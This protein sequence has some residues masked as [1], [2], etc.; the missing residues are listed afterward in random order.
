MISSFDYYKQ[1][2]SPNMYLC[3]PDR[4]FICALNAENRHLLLRFNDLSELS[5]TVPKISGTEDHY[6]L[7]ESKRLLFVEK[8]GWFQ[9]ESV[10]EKIVGEQ[11]TKEVK[12]H[13]HQYSFKNRGFISEERVYMFYNPYDPLDEKYDSNNKAAMPS[14]I[15]QLHQQLGV[16]V[17]LSVSDIEPSEDRGDWT[18]I[19]IDPVL[20]FRAR[21]YGSMYEP[22][23]NVENVCRSFEADED[24]N[25]YDFIINKVESAFEVIFEFDFLYH[26]IKVKTLDAITLPTDIYLSFDNIVNSLSVKENAEDIVT[27]MSCSGGD[28]DIRTVNPMGTNY[29][30]D[31]SYYKKEK[32]DDGKVEYPWMS[33]ELIEALNEWETEFE[34]YQ[35]EYSSIVVN[36]QSKYV[37]KTSSDEKIQFANLK[38]KDLQVARDQYINGEDEDIDGGG[39]TTAETVNVNG[40]SLKS[41]TRFYATPFNDSAIVVG[42]IAKPIITKGDSGIYTFVFSDV[43]VSGTVNSLIQNYYDEDSGFDGVDV[44]LYFMDED[45]YSYCK[46]N[47]GYVLDVAKDEDGNT[48]DFAYRDGS[49]WS[50]KYGHITIDGVTFIITKERVVDSYIISSGSFSL[51]FT[52]NS[53]FVY[54]GLRYRVTASADGIVSLYRYYVSGFDRFT[55]CKETAGTGGWCDLW[56]NLINNSLVPSVEAINAAISSLEKNLENINELCNIQKFIKKKDES[57]R[58]GGKESNLYEELFHYWIEGEYTNENISVQDSTTMAERIDLAK[59]LL[60]A[61]KVD[62][63]KSAQPKFEMS[64]DAINFIKMYEFRQFTNELTLGRTITIE[65][66][67]GIYYHPALM[68]IEY[69]IDSSD[70]FTMTFSNA[71]KPGDTAMTFADLIKESTGSTRNIE[72]NWSNI[73]DYSRNKEQI[74]RLIQ[75]P[76]DRSLRAMQAGLASQ[77]FII[78]EDGILGRKYD[79]DADGSKT[80]FSDEQIRIINNTIIFTTDNWETA[81]LALGKIQLGDGTEAYGLVADVL[82]GELILGERI[83]IGSNS[84]R[85]RIDDGGILIKNDDGDAVFEAD[86]DGNITLIGTVYATSG[87][88]SGTIK[89]A[90]GEIGGYVI[91]GDKLVGNKV[92]MRSN[93]T[94]TSPARARAKTRAATE[95]ITFWAGNDIA[96]D[97][98]FYVTSDGELHSTSGVIGGFTIGDTAIYNNR[99][100]L[101][102]TNAVGVYVGTDGISLGYDAAEQTPKIYASASGEFRALNAIIFGNATLTSCLVRGELSAKNAAI[103]N[104]SAS[105]FTTGTIMFSDTSYRLTAGS[106]GSITV[107]A[108]VSVN[109]FDNII[110][111]RC[112]DSSGNSYPLTTGR[113]FTVNWSGSSGILGSGSGTVTLT[114]PAGGSTSSAG[115]G[116]HYNSYDVAF[117]ASGSTRYYFVDSGSSGFGFNGNILPTSNGSYTLGDGVHYWKNIYQLGGSEGS[118]RKLKTDIKDLSE[119]KA[120]QLICGLT[121]RTYKFKVFDTPRAR[122]GFIAQEVEEVLLSMGLTTEDWALVNKTK[123]DEPDGVDNFYSMDYRG[124]IAPM[125]KVIQKLVSEI[126]ELQEKIAN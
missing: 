21:S 125:V 3:N 20:K 119:E 11:Y 39:I 87:E 25:G 90:R 100:T 106:L 96:S 52:S 126:R 17:A 37:D 61:G 105:N 41:G 58:A 13:S 4:R 45:A 19:Y 88:F 10:D 112:T 97:S 30:V 9:I 92:G 110:T 56:E 65:K 2:E 18:I 28:L 81:A 16:R 104:M 70:S 23:N 24:L 1:I 82:V 59:E 35:D 54:N 124:L 85:V 76:L 12:A 43:G 46:L 91:D 38:L 122:S 111:V 15:G 120:I 117:A 29:I 69:D 44:P 48:V 78:D 66:A 63:S 67:D 95:V 49:V 93:N 34:N 83:S 107:T 94:S 89:A 98:P 50:I 73:T 14:V 86:A 108:T 80:I 26:T 99:D 62:L 55:T 103:S 113:S 74:T 22:A 101:N 5:F 40:H 118:D 116:K 64:V 72:A 109:S 79:V 6:A 36:L 31:F 57:L 42:H 115:T 53:Y 32:S 60:A 102:N 77:A 8:I 123:P 51:E 71:S 27:V 33:K 7:V 68:S 75:A 121:P 114:I 84:E 47:V